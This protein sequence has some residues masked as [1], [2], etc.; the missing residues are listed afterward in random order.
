MSTFDKREDAYENKFAHDEELQ[1]KALA[2]AHKLLGLWAAEKLGKSGTA[3]EDYAKDLVAE[4]V[5]DHD[6]KKVVAAVLKE[7]T[8]AGVAQSEHQIV[9]HFEE[10]RAQALDAVKNS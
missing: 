2:R 5:V 9:R 7:F 3:A 8:A 4:G 6:S 1:F 10:F